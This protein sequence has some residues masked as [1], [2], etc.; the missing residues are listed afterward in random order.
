MPDVFQTSDKLFEHEWP[1][2]FDHLNYVEEYRPRVYDDANPNKHINLRLLFQGNATIG[3]GF[4]IAA[5]C[6][7]ELARHIVKFHA[8]EIWAAL[9][10]W[11][12][13]RPLMSPLHMS[14]ARRLVLVSMGVNM[15]TYGLSVWQ[16][17]FALMR[18]KNWEQAA[19][20]IERSLAAKQAP[21][22]Y[23]LLAR[24]MRE[25]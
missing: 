17:T 9:N 20:H 10:R 2:I 7:L 24:M 23:E 11:P 8:F 19:Q 16:Q 5:G 1:A 4:N 15:G 3:I 12:Q 21:V 14:A 13:T 25:G 6:S 22:R 18:E